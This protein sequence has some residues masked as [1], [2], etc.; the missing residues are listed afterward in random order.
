[1]PVIGRGL[2]DPFGHP[3][4]WGKQ[5]RCK[6]C[7]FPPRG[8]IVLATVVGQASVSE[9]NIADLVHHDMLA[10]KGAALIDL[11]LIAGIAAAVVLADRV[12]RIRLQVAGFIGCGAG[13]LLA[14]LSVGHEGDRLGIVL[15]FAGFMLYSFMNNLGPNSMT[16]LIAGEVF[17]TAVRGK[18]AGLAASTAKIGAVASAFFF[19]ILLKNIGTR[20][21]LIALVITSLLGA[22]LTWCLRIETA[23]VNLEEIDEADAGCRVQSS[24][25]GM[26]HERGESKE[27]S[28]GPIFGRCPETGCSP[29]STLV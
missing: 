9:R 4:G 6:P 21:I 17:P 24:H 22:L 23:G 28:P 8:G 13:L 20:P 29:G 7:H 2:L 14:A 3:I 16:Y 18:G 27:R 5:T 1:M 10:A 11:L 15:V 12:G 26:Q 19:P 25:A